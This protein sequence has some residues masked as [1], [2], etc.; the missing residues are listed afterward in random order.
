MNYLKKIAGGNNFFKK[1]EN[2]GNN[3]FH[4][5]AAF[6]NNLPSFA[7]SA[8]NAVKNIANEIQKK[9]SQYGGI[10]SDIALSLG[11]P[12]LA[13][14]INTG[15]SMINNYNSTLQNGINQGQQK[16]TNYSNMLAQ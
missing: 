5:T 12:E 6:V 8:G 9:S 1:A 2:F 4:K 3:M 15:R 16:I 13:G 14:L 11:R 7:Q 10:A